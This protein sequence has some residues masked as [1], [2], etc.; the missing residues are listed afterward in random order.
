MSWPGWEALD[1]LWARLHPGCEPV[2]ERSAIGP[3]VS[4]EG[5]KQVVAYPIRDAW[6]IG[7]YGLT[8]L[9]AKVSDIPHQDG[10]GYEL[11]VMVP[12]NDEADPPPWAM[13]LVRALTNYVNRTGQSLQ[14]NAWMSVPDG[15]GGK[16]SN[17]AGLV[18]TRD[19]LT[20]ALV[21]GPF[22]S[23]LF[24]R[25]VGV[26]AEE[27]AFRQQHG[28]RALLDKLAEADRQLFT[29]LGRASI[30]PA[31]PEREAIVVPASQHANSVDAPILRLGRTLSGDSELEIGRETSEPLAAALEAGLPQGEVVLASEYVRARFTVGASASWARGDVLSI[32][33]PLDVAKEIATSLRAARAPFRSDALPGLS[34]RVH[35]GNQCPAALAMSVCA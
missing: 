29:R 23:F 25:M 16:G 15:V 33:V 28:T 35:Q 8:E 2:W 1:A 27:L 17:L 30:V 18:F 22:G 4:P 11:T 19:P 3:E 31:G 20:P 10:F 13:H 12:R 14:E 24:R 34:I 32:V 6:H 26:T 7:G 5:C 21:K 9:F